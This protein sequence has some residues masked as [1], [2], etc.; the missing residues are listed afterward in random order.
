MTRVPT[1]PDHNHVV[2]HFPRTT[3]AAFLCDAREAVAMSGPHR[4]G[5]AAL[6]ACLWIA[7]IGVCALLAWLQV[8]P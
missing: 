3:Q 6:A 1:P 5:G 4:S 8:A 7:A 2:A